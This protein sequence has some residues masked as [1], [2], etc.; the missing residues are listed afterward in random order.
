MNEQPGVVFRESRLGHLA[1]ATLP[2]SLLFL[3]ASVPAAPVAAQRDSTSP[4]DVTLSLVVGVE[5]DGSVTEEW[6]DVLGVFHSEAELPAMLEDRHPLTDDEAAW[7]ALIR[8]HEGTWSS[9]VDSLRVPFGSVAPPPRVL[10]VMGNVGGQDG[11]AP[12]D[13][14]I[15]FDVR[16]LAKLYGG[17]AEAS[18]A[19]RIDRFFAH[20]FTH[21]LHKAWRK[22]HPIDLVTPLDRALWECLKEGVGNYRSLSARWVTPRGDLTTRARETLDRLQIVFVERLAALEHASDEDAEAL[23]EG[24]SMGPFTEK[25]GALTVAL[26][27]AQEA[28]GEDILLKRWIDAGPSGILTLAGKY[29]PEELEA[30]MPRPRR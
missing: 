11:F 12:S 29:L 24:L 21:L 30:R 16:R 10:V 5:R 3:A 2:V 23:L 17:A 8:S 22:E 15:A 18:N 1:M 27:L 7:V 6:V 13:T 19:N 9:A 14:T 25:W 26:W 20:E 4:A 28:R